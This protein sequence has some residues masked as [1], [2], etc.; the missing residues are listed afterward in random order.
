MTPV[1]W[2][3]SHTQS[4][5][6]CLSL[7]HR[8]PLCHRLDSASPPSVPATRS[9]EPGRLMRRVTH[10]H[11]LTPFRTPPPSRPTRVAAAPRRHRPV[12]Q[13]AL[14]SIQVSRA[15]PT[16]RTSSSAAFS[17]APSNS[18]PAG[19][20]R[21]RGRDGTGPGQESGADASAARENFLRAAEGGCG[22]RA[23]SL[24]GRLHQLRSASDAAPGPR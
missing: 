1:T 16:P 19:A 17:R 5:I 15:P 6:L 14:V 4:H 12:P 7:T 9:P 2:G 24:P 8:A 13:Q 18:S 21:T 3:L 23:P 10:S 20:G 22:A 11:G